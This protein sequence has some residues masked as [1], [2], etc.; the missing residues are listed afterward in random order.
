VTP[1]RVDLAVDAFTDPEAL[2]DLLN[3]MRCF[4]EGRH[5]WVAGPDA[6]AAAESYL[7]EHAPRLAGTYIALGTKGTV[8]TA[9]TGSA[10]STQVVVVTAFDLANHAADLC[11]P[12]VVVVEDHSSDGSYIRSIARVFGA[13]RLEL[14]LSEGWLEVQHGGGSRLVKVAETAVQRYRCLTRVVALLDSDRMVPAQR[15][16]AHDKA[17][18]LRRAGVLVHVLELREAENY[19]PNRVLHRIGRPREASRKL[20]LLSRLAPNQRGYLDMKSGFGP[21]DRPPTVPAEQRAL[22]ADLD[23]RVL[24]GLRGGFG[25]DLLQRLEAMSDGL[26]E[27]DFHPLGPDIVPELRRM[28]ATIVGVI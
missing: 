8:A 10:D 25:R 28:L 18:R 2:P 24:L 22:Y 26:S 4:V 13:T 17:D 21:G 5:D 16:A 20:D 27:R 12:A 9:W 23:R 19:V 1:V 14:A 7:A 3:L 15:T 6:I 11:R